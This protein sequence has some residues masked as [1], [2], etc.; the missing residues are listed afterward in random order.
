MSGVLELSLDELDE[1][2]ELAVGRK[3]Q[4]ANDIQSAKRSATV[5]KNLFIS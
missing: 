1:L 3:S 4:P 5:A 2:D